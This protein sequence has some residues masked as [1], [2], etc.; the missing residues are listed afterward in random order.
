MSREQHVVPRGDQW[1]VL[2]AGNSKATSSHSTQASAIE[3]AVKIAK[4][5]RAEVVIHRP[6]GTIRDKDSYGGDSNPP[7]DNKH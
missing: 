2:G 5:Q 7:K 4:H 3:A 1:A 6:D